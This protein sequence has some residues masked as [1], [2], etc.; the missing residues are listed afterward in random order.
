[1]KGPKKAAPPLPVPEITKPTTETTTEATE[2]ATEPVAASHT[3]E[4]VTERAVNESGTSN[5]L[6]YAI[7]A[8]VISVGAYFVFS[9][10]KK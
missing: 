4:P 8:A 1:M 10:L 6:Y 7:G 2:A 3:N 5:Y 9:K